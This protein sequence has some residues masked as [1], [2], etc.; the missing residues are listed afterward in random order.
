MKTLPS[1]LLIVAALSVGCRPALQELSSNAPAARHA[2]HNRQ[3]KGIMERLA[4]LPAERMPQELD[5]VRE[6]EWRREDAARILGAM[7]SSAAAIPTVLQNV[8]LTEEQRGAF[9]QLSEGLR[10]DSEALQNELIRLTPTEI[11]RRF[12]ALQAHCDACH[13]RFRV[14]PALE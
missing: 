7:A 9:R 3:L 12:D 5:V 10:R 2:L 13:S 1:I 11:G 4:M 6:Q 8:E 14:L